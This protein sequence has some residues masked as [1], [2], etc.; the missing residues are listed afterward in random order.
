M[1]TISQKISKS[2]KEQLKRKGADEYHFEKLV[3]DYC[4]LF[5]TKTKLQQDISENGVV[6][7]EYNV[8]GNEVH[9][10]NPAV[11]EVTRVVK[12]MLNIL[13]KLGINADDNIKDGGEENDC[14]L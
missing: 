6:L 14:G 7:T 2:L 3:D 4:M 11:A 13:D 9:K 1:A 5:E 12:A 8:K 10:T